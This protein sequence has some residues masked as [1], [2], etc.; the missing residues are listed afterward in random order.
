M[1]SGQGKANPEE[2][3]VY[4]RRIRRQNEPCLR[5]LSQTVGLAARC[6]PSTENLGKL[7][8]NAV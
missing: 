5:S 7:V 3:Q 4:A 2:A 6:S 8:E 1:G